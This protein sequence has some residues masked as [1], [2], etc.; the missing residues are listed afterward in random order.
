MKLLTNEEIADK[1][2]KVILA[3]WSDEELS[4][5]FLSPYT[6]GNFIQYH[7]NL[8]RWIRNE[9]QLWRLPRH[10]PQID[11]AGIDHSPDHPDQVSQTIIKMIWE[12]G[13][14]NNG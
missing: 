6:G 3:E 8:G 13:P 4:E 2:H 1:V 7:N 9:Y 10:K 11:E 14:Q 5:F 12:K